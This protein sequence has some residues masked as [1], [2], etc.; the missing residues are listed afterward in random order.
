MRAAFVDVSR[1]QG[2]IDGAQLKAAGFCAI[3]ARC[4]IGWSYKDAWYKNNLA[5][6]H[7]ND[8]IFGAYHVLWPAN[9]DPRREA[10]WFAENIAP[11]GYESPDF[12]VA[13]LELMGGRTA[14]QVA[15]QIGLLLPA[16]EA[17][18]GLHPWIYTGAWF[19][20]GPDYLGPATPIG[21]EQDYPLWH[22]SYLT[23]PP[24]KPRWSPSDA[25]QEPSEPVRLGDG[26]DEWAVWQW[27]SKGQP[28]GVESKT[29]DYDVF[30][31]TEE[32]FRQF[33]GLD[34]PPPTYEQKVDI[35]W[36]AHPELHPSE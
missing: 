36:E 33:I 6:A 26:W 23:P 30:N 18:V 2:K 17:E 21:I 7:D 25:P 15:T 11:Q 29:L 12:V 1:Y 3:V 34:S 22:A 27:T 31:G 24:W 16:M 8:M 28:I 35:L 13:D 14:A 5:E 9:N 19:W 10:A 20:N 32:E 4:T